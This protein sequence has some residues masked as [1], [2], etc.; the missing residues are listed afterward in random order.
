MK[1]LLASIFVRAAWSCAPRCDPV[2][3]APTS[4]C[5]RSTDGGNVAANTPFTLEGQVSFSEGTCSA[6]VLDGGTIDLLVR[7][8]SCGTANG[9][10]AQVA[11][12]SPVPCAIPAL[13]D[14][15]Y[16]VNSQPPVTFA[17]P[18]FDVGGLPICG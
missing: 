15:T 10:S 7:G 5:F 4:L 8:N 6:V 17:I 16:T 2:S 11:R 1:T 18:A 12:P 3:V 13:P 14:G 9:Q